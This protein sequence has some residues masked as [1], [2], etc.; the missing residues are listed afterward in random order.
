MLTLK[1]N[2]EEAAQYGVA[3][4]ATLFAALQRV[5]SADA[6]QADAAQETTKMTA[7]FE[8]L[9]KRVE[10]LEAAIAT[11]DET[12]AQLQADMIAE[13]VAESTKACA[14]LLSKIGTQALPVSQPVVDDSPA[15]NQI[16]EDDYDGQWKS[17]AEIRQEFRT[18]SVYEAFK[19][20]EA[21]GQVKMLK[22]V[23]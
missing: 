7:E 6:A 17:N 16:A 8:A 15:S 9:T 5:A 13:A 2:D 22:R 19:R 12:A 4:K 20:A 21:S 18:Q 11:D 14:G 1:L 3:D 10:A 23:R